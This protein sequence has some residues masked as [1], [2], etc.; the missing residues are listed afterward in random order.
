[1][2]G[3]KKATVVIK[4][5]GGLALFSPGHKATFNGCLAIKPNKDTLNQEAHSQVQL[6]LVPSPG[7]QE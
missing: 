3:D 1:M 2:S 4:L 5:D 6:S 7:I